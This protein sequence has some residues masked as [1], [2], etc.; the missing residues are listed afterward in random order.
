MGQFS[1]IAC[2]DKKSILDN[3]LADVYAIILTK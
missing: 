2:D 3:E 1:W